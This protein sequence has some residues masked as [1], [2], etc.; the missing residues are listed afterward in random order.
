[1]GFVAFPTPCYFWGESQLDVPS[2]NS[3]LENLRTVSQL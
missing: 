2:E 3:M 1:M